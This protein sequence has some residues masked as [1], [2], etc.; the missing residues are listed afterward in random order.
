MQNFR[1]YNEILSIMKKL[2]DKGEIKI[3]KDSFTIQNLKNI[4]LS[5]P[6][7][8]QEINS[9]K[10]KLKSQNEKNSNWFFMLKLLNKKK[11][12]NS[13][14]LINNIN[15]NFQ[16][17]MN[18]PKFIIDLNKRIYELIIDDLKMKQAQYKMIS[19]IN[20]NFSTEL[21]NIKEAFYKTNNFSDIK[22]ELILREIYEA[23]NPNLNIFM[24]QSE[25]LLTEWEKR[26]RFRFYLNGYSLESLKS[27]YSKLIF[28]WCLYNEE[29]I[30][31]KKRRNTFFKLAQENNK[32]QLL[33]LCKEGIPHS[34]RK[35]VYS[36]LLNVSNHYQIKDINQNDHV[37]IF[38]Y[39]ILKDAHKIA[40][41]E[42]Y[43]LFEENLIKLLCLMI[44]DHNL[45]TEIQGIRPMLTLNLTKND[46]S[47]LNNDKL[48]VLNEHLKVIPIKRQIDED[49]KSLFNDKDSEQ[50]IIKS[51]DKKSYKTNID[52]EYS[53]NPQI[54]LP[55]PPSGLF[56]SY[57]FAFQMAP[58]TYMS[59]NIDDFY[60]I[61]K[62]F[63]GKY[64]S[65]LSSY[66]SNKKSILSLLS[67]FDEIFYSM[68]CFSSLKNHFKI[69]KFDINE[70]I[71]NLFVTSFSN[72][73][74]PQNVF[75]IY[76]LIIITDNMGI[77]VLFGLSIVYYLK[78]EL[79]NCNT[80]EEILSTFENIIYDQCDCLELMKDFINQV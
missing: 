7:F 23:V 19:I 53:G 80:K 10:E 12:K 43:F 8:D 29:Q 14:L 57:G 71:I 54:Y 55:F 1:E 6:Q 76:D 42:N 9:L 31:Q 64:L 61:A 3:T 67:S 4:L 56:P 70:E 30:N 2:I 66:T 35:N 38:D 40:A 22:P 50:N 20:G 62:L 18:E 37:F 44:R 74:D 41:G 34:L 48:N 25:N 5:F 79:L 47:Y 32:M 59:N 15:T 33:E 68:E 45:I 65:F 49:D 69:K 39:Y 73:V 27:T 46:N 28:T 24:K 60:L 26:K 13:L 75:K 51:I 21:F 52:S 77:F 78:D 36:C 17:M 58:F 11:G 63:Y 16:I 72:V